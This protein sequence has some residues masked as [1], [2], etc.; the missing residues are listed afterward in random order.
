MSD[1]PNEMIFLYIIEFIFNA[2]TRT[3]ANTA[4]VIF[5]PTVRILSA[6]FNVPA[7]LD[8]VATVSNAKVRKLRM[9]ISKY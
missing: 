4:P 7:T 3:N 6:V 9:H 8:I 5:L 2:Q 1:K